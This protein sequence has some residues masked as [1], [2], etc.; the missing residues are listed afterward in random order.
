MFNDGIG[1]AQSK[2][3]A[4]EF[5][6]KASQLGSWE[7]VGKIATQTLDDCFSEMERVFAAAD[8]QINKIINS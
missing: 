3:K 1:V 4:K 2:T 5:Y 8:Q 6:R 7:A